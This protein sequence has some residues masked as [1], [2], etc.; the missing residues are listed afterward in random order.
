M[1]AWYSPVK[2]AVSPSSRALNMPSCAA[3]VYSASSTTP[4][5]RPSGNGS[6]SSLMKRRFIGNASSTPMIDTTHIQTIMC[7]HGMI[8]PVTSM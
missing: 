8:R 1:T 7:H 3:P 6:C 4:L 5:A 2:S